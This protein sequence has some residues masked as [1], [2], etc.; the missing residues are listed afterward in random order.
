MV[1]HIVIFGPPTEA[2]S[3]T[4]YIVMEI[5]LVSKCYFIF[6]TLGESDSSFKKEGVQMVRMQ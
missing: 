5:I 1:V 4:C 2:H 3:Y 6:I